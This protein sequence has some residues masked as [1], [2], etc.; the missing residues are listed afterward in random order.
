MNIMQ[1]AHARAG[2]KVFAVM[3]P[4]IVATYY[5]GRALHELGHLVFAKMLGVPVTSVEWVKGQVNFG[6]APV[7]AERVVIDYS[8]GLFAAAVLV[9]VIVLGTRILKSGWF[10]R[11]PYR[12]MVGM[13][14]AGTAGMRFCGGIIEGAFFDSYLSGEWTLWAT[15]PSLFVGAGLF[16]AWVWIWGTSQRQAPVGQVVED[17]SGPAIASG[18]ATR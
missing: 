8:G 10:R 16:W 12:W 4:A 18:E 11:A 9:G 14:L 5:L 17:A 13:I 15:V 7:G 3:P 1:K 6:V 2:L